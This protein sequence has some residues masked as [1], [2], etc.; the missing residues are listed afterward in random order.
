MRI[1]SHTFVQHR[2]SPRFVRV[3][4]NISFGGVAAEYAEK[5]GSF[6]PRGKGAQVAQILLRRR[7]ALLRFNKIRPI[8]LQCRFRDY[9]ILC[10]LCVFIFKS[11]YKKPFGKRI[12]PEG[13]L[14]FYVLYSA[15]LFVCSRRSASVSSTFSV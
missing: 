12:F 6:Y 14:L 9:F 15:C 13:L 4:R 7:R 1:M 3:E 10:L 2:K 11:K 5:L 8:A